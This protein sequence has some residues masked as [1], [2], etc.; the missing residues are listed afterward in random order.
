MTYRNQFD[1]ELEELK[2]SLI[3]MGDM[4]IDN[5]N[6]GFRSFLSLDIAL[7]QSIIEKD[8]LV[9]EQEYKIEKECM[10]I[11]L[12]EQPVA[13]DLRLITA[14]L[15]MITD[16]ER[17]GDHAADISKMTIFM[18]NTHHHFEAKQAGLI[19]QACSKMISQSLES[20]VNNDIELAFEVIREDDIVDNYFDE[21]KKSVA[22][23]IRS[24]TIDADY[25]LYL[26]M[27]AKYLERIGDH[28]VNIAEWVIFS[29][30]GEHKRLNPI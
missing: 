13:K 12:R 3:H 25:A 15:K 17:I 8:K 16:L 7:A 11:I 23:A 19:T 4:V 10:R 27:V 20:F 26:M 6:E 28:A 29:I 18:E 5:I 21:I 14:V 2:L 24:S 9:N 22:D 1:K 30:T